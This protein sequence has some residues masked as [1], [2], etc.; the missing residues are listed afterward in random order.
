MVNW[1]ALLVSF[2]DGNSLKENFEAGGFGVSA[3][4]WLEFK[5]AFW[6]KS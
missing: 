2:A 1:G 4:F 6:R 3:S 5:E